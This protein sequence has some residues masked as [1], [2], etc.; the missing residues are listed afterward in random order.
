MLQSENYQSNK[1]QETHHKAVTSLQ[2]E[3]VRQL[4]SHIMEEL[5]EM[6]DHATIDVGYFV[7]RQS[8][9]VWLVS[10]E[11]G[12]F[13]KYHHAFLFTKNVSVCLHLLLQFRQLLVR[14]TKV[15]SHFAFLIHL[16]QNLHLW[17]R[18]IQC[19]THDDYDDP[20]HVPMITGILP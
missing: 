12:V 2:F 17:A 8:A 9:K 15:Q 6:P 7:G 20:P 14:H 10:G 1:A 3:S 16:L 19:G 13:H 5:V 11:A 18:M 4:K